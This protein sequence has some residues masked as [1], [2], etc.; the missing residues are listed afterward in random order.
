M[1]EKLKQKLKIKVNKKYKDI[2]TANEL[3]R[4]IDNTNDLQGLKTIERIVN[5]NP[6]TTDLKSKIILSIIILL[7]IIGVFLCF[8]VTDIPTLTCSK[9]ENFCRLYTKTLLTPEYQENAFKITDIKN[10]T[11]EEY[12]HTGRG[13][14][15]TS[16]EP[17]LI[18]KNDDY[19][20]LSF[21]SRTHEDAEDIIYGIFNNEQYTKK[22]SL[23]KSFFD[24]Y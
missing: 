16:Y 11:I 20:Y 6:V 3:Y 7:S 14:H 8:A 9:S 5:G 12:H 24:T 19:D 10:Y 22:G 18:L 1:N 21:N 13:N 15:Y 2:E 4:L 23:F 17:V